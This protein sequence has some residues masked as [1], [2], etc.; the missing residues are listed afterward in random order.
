MKIIAWYYGHGKIYEENYDP[1]NLE[2]NYDF[3]ATVHHLTRV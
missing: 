3:M 1:R 2:I